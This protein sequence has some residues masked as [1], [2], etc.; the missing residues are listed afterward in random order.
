MEIY[1]YTDSKEVAER[2]I[3]HVL[4]ELLEGKLPWLDVSTYGADL[5][6]ASVEVYTF[7]SLLLGFEKELSKKNKR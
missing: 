7:L 1:E 2:I 6:K 4:E 3:E 5:D